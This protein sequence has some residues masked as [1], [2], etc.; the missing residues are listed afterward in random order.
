[1]LLV[2]VVVLV[3]IFWTAHDFKK[4]GAEVVNEKN[5]RKYLDH[6]VNDNGWTKSGGLIPTYTSP[7]GKKGCYADWER[8][9]Y[10][11]HH[12]KKLTTAEIAAFF[13]QFQ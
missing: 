11:C 3:I 10:A 2:V 1:M 12:K 6:L 5:I 8:Q 9:I 13:E 4:A 7:C